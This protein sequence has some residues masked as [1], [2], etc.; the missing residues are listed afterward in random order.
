MPATPRHLAAALACSLLFAPASIAQDPDSP[1]FRPGDHGLESSPIV[2]ERLGLTLYP[3]LGSEITSLES[4]NVLTLLIRDPLGSWELRIRQAVMRMTDPA[5]SPS[6]VFGG[7]LVR[8]LQRK[9]AAIAGQQAAA[10]GNRP[11]YLVCSEMEGNA[12]DFHIAETGDDR[13][14]IFHTLCDASEAERVRRIVE[15]TLRTVRITTSAEL[16]SRVETEFNLARKFLGTLTE[17][18][19][20]SLLGMD[21][22]YRVYEPADDREL[23]YFHVGVRE[24]KR[25]ELNPERDPKNFGPGENDLGLLVGV[26][27]RYLEKPAADGMPAIYADF[28]VRMWQMWDRSEEAWLIKVTHRQGE[29]A[30]TE[31]E[32]GTRS[33][34][35][36]GY[37]KLRVVKNHRQLG[38][39]N[40]FTWVIEEP[41][42]TQP[43][44]Y[45]LGHL[46]PRDGS[47][48]GPM[49]FRAY[50]GANEDT[51]AL[52]VRADEW[53]A[54]PAGGG[55]W[56]LE[57]RPVP[58]LPPVLSI[59]NRSGEL[60]RREKSGG[61]IT[62]PTTQQMLLD[63]WRRKGL[64][65][66]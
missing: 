57:S 53:Q 24:G 60:I 56:V 46:L 50:E 54:D 66:R 58:D 3:P 7:V 39:H 44:V 25:G 14:L 9:G 65:T 29:A 64:P 40:T 52:P 33:P 15:P 59:F 30:L 41:Y 35:S 38:E 10:I 28:Q 26:D 23:G 51:R 20:R 34:E 47:I 1:A 62:E 16:A 36:L 61:V 6:E 22:W 12:G 21:E 2:N 31:S 49:R 4:N 43:E 48:T 27:A 42:L 5:V 8:D 32:S 63:L 55:Q 18:R 17:D 13:F 37:S 19:L 11:G 45:L